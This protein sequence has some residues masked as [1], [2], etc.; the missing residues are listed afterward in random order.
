MADA[1]W[2]QEDPTKD[3]DSVIQPF[4]SL[5]TGI[6]CLG[7][8]S[9]TASDHI[10]LH[11]WSSEADSGLNMDPRSGEVS[12]D[13]NL[14]GDFLGVFALAIEALAGGAIGSGTAAIEAAKHFFGP[15]GK[16]YDLTDLLKPP[17]PKQP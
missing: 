6:R 12:E 5:S 9:G 14:F 4:H 2:V 13:G 15:S 11:Y 17:L 3:R 10:H 16:E 1:V 7:D 8:T